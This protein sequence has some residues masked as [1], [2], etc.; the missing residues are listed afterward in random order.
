MVAV[1]V[2][3]TSGGDL[4]AQTSHPFAGPVTHPT[5]SLIP[6]TGMVDVNRDGSPDVVVP[7]LFFGPMMST[8]DEH[9]G[10]LSTNIDGPSLSVPPGVT[11]LPQVLA[12]AGGRFDGDSL[13][14]LVSVSSNGTLHFHKNLGSTRI[15]QSNWAPDVIF[16]DVRSAY[17]ANPP[18]VVYSFPVAKQFDFDQDGN[19][20]VLVGGGPIDRWSGATKPGFVCIYRGDGQGGF[21]PLRYGLPGAVVDVE[22]AD[23]DKDG[24]AEGLV[25]LVETGSVGV[26][27]Y[28]IVHLDFT[29][30]VLVPQGLSQAIGPGRLTAL[31]LGDVS[32]D[33]HDDYIVSQVSSS[34]GSVSSTVYF[35]EGN[36]QGFVNPQAWGTLS[37]PTNVMGASDHVASIQVE[38]FD[39]DGHDD[40]AV[41]R[42]YLHPQSSSTPATYYESEVLIGMGPSAG[43]AALQPVALPGATNFA[44]SHLFSLRP[45]TPQPEQLRVVSLGGESGTDLMVAGLRTGSVYN[46]PAIVTLKNQTPPQLGDARQVKIGDASGA[47]TSRLARIGFEGGRPVPGNADFACTIQNVQGGCLVGLMWNQIAIADLFTI[48]G[49]TMHLGPAEYGY[50]ALASGSQWNDGFYSYSLPIPNNPALV[51]DAGC[52]QYCYYDHVTGRFGGTQATDVWIGN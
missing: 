19:L 11:N 43:S 32:G 1:L 51:G 29:S 22:V 18:F 40:I 20:D 38:D 23:L 42:G 39:L 25:V 6:A 46:Y 7:G 14:D 24:V 17:P 49:F 15:D 41:L 16:D 4:I 35:Y 8:L 5:F 12:M 26:F 48:N 36:G 31:E 52:F 2:A 44:D 34:P 28:E 30:G 47:V 33:S 21:Q 3:F 13:Q 27:N 9:G 37:L 45:L 10:A 50:P